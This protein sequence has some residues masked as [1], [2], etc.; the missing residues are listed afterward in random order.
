MLMSSTSGED[1]VRICEGHQSNHIERFFLHAYL[2]LSM[3]HNPIVS[4]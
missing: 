4:M 3:L 1:V 2:L